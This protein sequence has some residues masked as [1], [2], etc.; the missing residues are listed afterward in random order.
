MNPQW[1]IVPLGIAD[2]VE[3][4]RA[5]PYVMNRFALALGIIERGYDTLGRPPDLVTPNPCVA[6]LGRSTMPDYANYD[7]FT[8][9]DVRE[10]H[11]RAR[12]ALA[13]ELDREE[14]LTPSEAHWYAYNDPISTPSGYALAVMMNFLTTTIAIPHFS[15][16]IERLMRRSLVP[17]GT[18]LVLGGVGGKYREIYP[19][20]DQRARTAHLRVL[21]GFADPLQAGQRADELAVLCT[22]TRSVWEKLEA[23]ADDVEQT[24]EELRA[25]GA[26]DIFDA[27]VPFRLPRFRVR[28]YRRGR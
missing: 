13:A 9:L 20:L 28:A 5:M 26:A 25:R 11:N 17:G 2:I 6:E 12:R 16:A 4:S 18:V 10:E 7:D 24:K 21:H 8:T 3:R 15:E 23:L 14:D 19:E 27:S 22:L 1:P